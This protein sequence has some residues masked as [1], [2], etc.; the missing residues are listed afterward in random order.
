MATPTLTDKPTLSTADLAVTA[1]PEATP[2]PG[3]RRR[4]GHI[5]LTVL[6]SIVS[7]LVLGLV[8]VLGV[9]GGSE[10]ATITGSALISL[11]AGMLILFLLA[12]RR[13][14]QPQPWALVPAIALGA[15]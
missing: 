13:T 8:L 5:G 11:G 1:S 10:E 15:V 4:R 6:G 14:D 7:G 9:F 12:G 2:S 3:E